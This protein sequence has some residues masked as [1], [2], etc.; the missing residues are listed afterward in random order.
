MVQPTVGEC[1]SYILSPQTQSTI[2]TTSKKDITVWGGGWFLSMFYHLV[3][4]IGWIE[5]NDL[6]VYELCTCVICYKN[7]I[8]N[9]K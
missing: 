2:N 5:M 9:T 1:V 7:A 8:N 4:N 6:C 3:V